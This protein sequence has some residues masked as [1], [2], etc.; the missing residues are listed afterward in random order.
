VVSSTDWSK[1]EFDNAFFFLGGVGDRVDVMQDALLG[2]VGMHAFGGYL[3]VAFKGVFFSGYGTDNVADDSKLS[4]KENLSLWNDYLTLLY[5]NEAIGGIRFD[6]LFRDKTDPSISNEY[7]EGAA[8]AASPSNVNASYTNGV[9]T[10]LEWTGTIGALSPTVR[11]GVKWPDYTMNEW[12]ANIPNQPTGDKKAEKWENSALD[13]YL[14][15]GGL[16][17]EGLSVTNE[18]VIEFQDTVKGDINVADYTLAENKW[19][20]DT[21]RVNYSKT[22]DFG[23]KFQL[24]LRPRLEA[25]F[26]GT[27]HKV[28]INYK[29]YPDGYNKEYNT[30]APEFIFQLTPSVDAG[31]KWSPTEKLSF[32]TGVNVKPLVWSVKWEDAYEDQNKVKHKEYKP[33]SWTV[34]PLDAIGTGTQGELKFAGT[35]QANDQIGIELS[36]G[37]DLFKIG[38]PG[39]AA[40]TSVANPF[41]SSAGDIITGGTLVVKFAL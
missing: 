41:S 28:A 18:L 23:E 17:V 37:T 9:T 26:G 38:M 33:V 5:G 30:A 15:T 34:D 6:L 21:F 40:Q 11:V 7:G 10:S 39:S 35:F 29:N 4:K 24:K 8:M 20:V 36:F 31:A 14:S 25:K 16:P 12:A 13:I 2:G 22:L 3:G 32:Y 19:W 1:L 27:D